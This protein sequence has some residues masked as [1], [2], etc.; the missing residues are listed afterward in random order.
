[1]CSVLRPSIVRVSSVR[2]VSV[3]RERENAQA[4]APSRD[5]NGAGGDASISVQER[6]STLF[7][8]LLELRLYRKVLI[9]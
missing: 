5:R 6:T 7:Y 8:D 4:K 3:R 2:S 1:M 9:D